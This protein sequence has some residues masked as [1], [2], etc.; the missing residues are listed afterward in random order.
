MQKL[1]KIDRAACKRLRPLLDAHL[2]TL[3]AQLG[4]RITAGNAS[5]DPAGTVTF[6]IDIEL[7][8]FD[9]DK[10]EFE[11]NCYAVPGLEPEHF[12]TE[13][14]YAGRKF[15]LVG[16]KPRASKWPIVGE[17]VE[18]PDGGKRFKLPPGAAQAVLKEWSKVEP[19]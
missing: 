10:H 7:E 12:H 2:A 18:G 14:H 1:Q 11:Q 13:F 16:V 8:G 9:R 17:A 5:Y 19:A 4:C 15:K 6:K 3:G